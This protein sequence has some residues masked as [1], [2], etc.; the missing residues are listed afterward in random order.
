MTW[1]DDSR[2]ARRAR[3]FSV[4]RA[5]RVVAPWL[6]TNEILSH[7]GNGTRRT[8]SKSSVS[9]VLRVAGE[10]LVAFGVRPE[11]LEDPAER[12]HAS[13]EHRGENRGLRRLA[14]EKAA[15]HEEAGPN[16]RTAGNPAKQRAGNVV[17]RRLTHCQ[18]TGNLTDSLPA[19]TDGPH[20]L[21]E[22]DERGF[23]RGGPK[24]RRG[25]PADRRDRDRDEEAHVRA[26]VRS[27][28]RKYQQADRHQQRA[29]HRD[30]LAPGVH[31][32]PE[33]AH[34]IEESGAG[35]NLKNDAERVARGIHQED[36]AGRCEEEAD[37]D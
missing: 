19:G 7:G 21:I 4:A 37:G 18:R 1:G 27:A 8:L 3:A 24:V 22:G 2:G 6:I 26:Q 14:V 29:H 32:P 16:R 36:G 23:V 11:S 10:A 20:L 33:P 5:V 12:G 17:A 34:Q 9:S 28:L 35:A 13:D 31:P 15:D 25:H 30:D